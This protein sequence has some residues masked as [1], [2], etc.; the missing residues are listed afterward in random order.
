MREKNQIRNLNLAVGIV[1]WVCV[2]GLPL[3][4][5]AAEVDDNAEP[6]PSA[7]DGAVVEGAAQSPVPDVEVNDNAALMSAGNG[8][9]DAEVEGPR[10][11]FELRTGT[12]SSQ[13]TLRIGTQLS[14][15]EEPKNGKERER[16]S[17]FTALAFTLAGPL[18]KS[19]GVT[20]LATLDGLSNSVSAGLKINRFHVT[21]L[22]PFLDS[23]GEVLRSNGKIVIPP[24]IR[25]F[26][27]R[28][29]QK[30]P[31]KKNEVGKR[32]EEYC[33][34][35]QI[36]D[37]TVEEHLG[38]AAAD[39]F[40]QQFFTGGTWVYGGEAKVGVQEY[41]FLESE[42]FDKKDSQRTLWSFG[43]HG[44]YANHWLGLASL[45]FR[46]ERSFK[47]S[48]PETMCIEIEEGLKCASGRFGG[49]DGKEAYVLDLSLRRQI[50]IVTVNRIFQLERLAVAPKA[51]FDFEADVFG[52]D[53]PIYLWGTSDGNLNGGF[54]TGWR[55]DTDNFVFSIFVGSNFGFFN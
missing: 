47:E 2:F 38:V 16:R 9:A 35:N 53:L 34:R 10:S 19:D 49:P 46:Y 28:L 44:G 37:A 6:V 23:E 33:R 31:A 41:E 43:V 42:S 24:E 39:R 17:T 18:D 11:L 21:R 55:D 27:D 51:S 26:C 32:E 1:A 13:V 20:D 45:A 36:D 4:V 30:F 25:P 8:P 50:P 29:E 40:E 54:R 15:S 7:V 48:D 3:S 22:N 5:A 12:E 14:R 52:I